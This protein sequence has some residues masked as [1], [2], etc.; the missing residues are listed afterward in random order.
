MS[1][2]LADPFS[3]GSQENSIKKK[4][5]KKKG[6]SPAKDSGISGSSD[7]PSAAQSPVLDEKEEER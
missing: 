6:S 5:T 1:S 4:R 7:S 2:S 3:I